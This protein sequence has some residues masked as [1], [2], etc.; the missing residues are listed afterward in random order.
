MLKSCVSCL[1]NLDIWV[2]K[3][4]LFLPDHEIL[5]LLG[6]ARVHTFTVSLKTINLIKEGPFKQVVQCVLWILRTVGYH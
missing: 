1:Q 3:V 5:A 4:F 6:I 2:I